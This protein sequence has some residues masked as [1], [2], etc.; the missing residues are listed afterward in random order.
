MRH[1]MLKY[2]EMYEK[3]QK[4]SQQLGPAF[5]R[6]HFSYFSALFSSLALPRLSFFFTFL[7]FLYILLLISDSCIVEKKHQ[8][9][10]HKWTAVQADERFSLLVKTVTDISTRRST[11]HNHAATDEM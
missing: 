8:D 4:K 5:I 7:P 6:S 1:E 2:K 9:E 3:E 11:A 10:L